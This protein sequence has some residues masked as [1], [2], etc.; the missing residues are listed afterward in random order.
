[1]T[2][3]RNGDGMSNETRV[4]PSEDD[5][6]NELT[7]GGTRVGLERMRQHDETDPARPMPT[8]GAVTTREVVPGPDDEEEPYEEEPYSDGPGDNLQD[9]SEGDPLSNRTT[10]SN[11]AAVFADALR[12]R[13][14]NKLYGRNPRRIFRVDEHEGPSTAGGLLARQSISLVARKGTAHSIVCGWMDVSRREAV[15]RSYRSVAMRHFH[16]HGV[17]IDLTQKEYD[18]FLDE[19]VD[20]LMSGQLRVQILV[21]EEVE[22]A[23][24]SSTVAT[25]APRRSGSPF[26]TLFLVMLVFSLGM[27]AERFLHLAERVL[28]GL[29]R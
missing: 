12:A 1:M 22:A 8:R 17:E 27:L 10:F 23:P 20:F 9:P 14:A 18:R 29:G 25:P 7:R 2:R 6:L 26:G 11:Q 21:P 13:F 24:A 28:P 15:L 19:L 5:D 16:R 4:A 3:Q